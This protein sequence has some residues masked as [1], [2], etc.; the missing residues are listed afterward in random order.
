MELQLC[1]NNGN[2]INTSN[3]LRIAAASEWVVNWCGAHGRQAGM[4]TRNISDD[5]LMETVWIMNMEAQ[6]ELN[7]L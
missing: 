1:A 3:A 6:K 5:E 7:E 4:Q 2:E